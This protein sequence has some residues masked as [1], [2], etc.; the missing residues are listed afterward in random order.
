MKQAVT[1]DVYEHW[2]ALKRAASLPARDAFDPGAIRHCLANVFLLDRDDR[3]G[4]PV[5]IAGTAICG[6][7]GRELRL[8]PFTTICASDDRPTILHML[9]SVAED[10]VGAVMRAAGHNAGGEIADLEMLLL[11]LA[12]DRGI[13]T[14]FVGA[15]TPIDP[16]YWLS[17]RPIEAIRTSQPRYLHETRTKLERPL[18][19]SGPGFTLYRATARPG[20]NLGG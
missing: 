17:E 10:R 5:R 19:P 14:R 8:Q 1:R 20:Q 3:R 16:P 12:G 4:H 18:A 11:P 6:F 2:S 15:L 7:F 13:A 9:D